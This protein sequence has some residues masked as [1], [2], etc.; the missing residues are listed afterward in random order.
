M[1]MK[2]FISLFKTDEIEK[3]TYKSVISVIL[4]RYGIEKKYK[5]YYFVYY[6]SALQAIVSKWLSN[7]CDLAINE[8]ADLMKRL[9]MKNE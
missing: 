5:E 8:V 6:V 7:N 3:S 9:V 4:D 2:I 1:R